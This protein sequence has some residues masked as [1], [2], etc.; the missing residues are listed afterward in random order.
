[1][2][3]VTVEFLIDYTGTN[4]TYWVDA[5]GTISAGGTYMSGSATAPGQTATWDATIDLLSLTFPAGSTA[6]ASIEILEEGDLPPCIPPLPDILT[7]YIAVEIIAG[8]FDGTVTV[9]VHY[10]DTLL[11]PEQELN[12]RLYMADCVDFN[13]DGTINGQDNGLIQEALLSGATHSDPWGVPFDVDNDGDVDWTDVEIVHQYMSQGLIVNEGRNG[14]PQARLPYIDITTL[15]DTDLNI[16][17]GET[18]H[19]S[20]FGLR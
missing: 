7:P 10:D 18:W 15:I 19:F 12:L 14:R 16:I 11:T 6:V 17:Y 4:P 1:V 20:I 8:D 5:E 13:L 2:D 9:A 3:G